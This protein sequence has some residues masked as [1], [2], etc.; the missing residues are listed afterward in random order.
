MSLVKIFARTAVLSFGFAMAI[1]AAVK[2]APLSS[3]RDI[4]NGVSVTEADCKAQSG[5][6]W[7]RVENRGFCVRFW[8][9]TAGGSNDEPLVYLHGDIFD[10]INGKPQLLELARAVSDESQQK[11]ADYGSRLYRGAYF[12]I[13][14]PG[15]YGSSGHHLNDKATLLEI[16]VASAALDALKRQLWFHAVPSRRPVRRWAHRCRA[17]AVAKRHWL[18]RDRI[19]RNFFTFIDARQ[20]APDCREAIRDFTIRS[21]M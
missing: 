2:A 15:A 20:R 13:A 8:L 12:F 14:R 10:M 17:R 16:R 21:T 7:V 11:A 1:G 9:S 19:R 5:R 18:R 3:D 6:L 4:I